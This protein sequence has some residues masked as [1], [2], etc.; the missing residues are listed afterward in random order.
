MILDSTVL[1]DVLRDRT[2]KLR[3]KLD[4]TLEGKPY[5]LTRWTQLELLRGAA[6]D[7]QWRAL[8]EHLVGEAYIESTEETWRGAARIL[9]EL[10][11]KGKSVRSSVDC[12]IAQLAIEHDMTVLH[13]DRDF[14]VIATVRKLKHTRLALR[15]R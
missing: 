3:R 4:E 10:K 9:Y 2:G 5:V 6:D 14:D 13:N 1:I 15:M 7:R 12:C 8:E 11:R